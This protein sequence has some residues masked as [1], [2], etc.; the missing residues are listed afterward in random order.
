M[1]IHALHGYVMFIQ[2]RVIE[3]FETEHL[4]RPRLCTHFE[5]F[6]LEDLT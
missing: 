5:Y 6:V 2:F 1:V 4:K 3:G